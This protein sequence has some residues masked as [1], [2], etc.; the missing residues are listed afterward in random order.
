VQDFEPKKANEEFNEMIQKRP[1][2]IVKNATPKIQ[3]D[4]R[5]IPQ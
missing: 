2:F 1:T 3:K 4:V 5:A